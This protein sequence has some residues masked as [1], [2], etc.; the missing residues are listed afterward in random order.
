MS[1]FK[2]LGSV[3]KAC[4]EVLKD[5]EGRVEKAS[6]AFGA[7]CKPVFQDSSL[8]FKTKRMVY[9]AMVLEV[10]IY[11]AEAWVNKRAT[12]SWSRSITRASDATL[13]IAKAQQY[14]SYITFTEVRRRTFG[15]EKVLED[16]VAVKRLCWV[17]HVAHMNDCH[18]PKKTRLLFGWLPQRRYTDGTKLG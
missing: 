7:L 5:V 13:G 17:G 3:V 10:V 14:I 2:Y 15:V 11:V 18:L 16:V 1:K 6:S 9:C 4:G 8:F 12:T